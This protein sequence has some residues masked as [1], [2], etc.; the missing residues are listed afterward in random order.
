VTS[1][2][3]TAAALGTGDRGN[4]GSSPQRQEIVSAVRGL[5]ASPPV[6]HLSPKGIA[7]AQVGMTSS[8]ACVSQDAPGAADERR[9][10]SAGD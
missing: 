1:V 8:A 9:Q 3:E 5:P 2:A 4:P 6:P 7:A 10:I